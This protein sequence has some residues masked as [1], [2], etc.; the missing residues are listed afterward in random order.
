[1]SDEPKLIYLDSNDFSDLS[2]PIENLNE[3]DR[4]I[5]QAIRNAKKNNTARFFVSPIHLSEA[6]HASETYREQAIS[7]AKLMQELAAGN[8]LQLPT[9][10]CKLELQRAFQGALQVKCSFSEIIS[11]SDQWFGITSSDDNLPEL[12]K[13]IEKNIDEALLPLNRQERRRRKSELDIRKKSGRTAIRSLIK[14]GLRNAPPQK[15]PMSL[16]NPELATKWFLR[17]ATDNDMRE[18]SLRLANDPYVLFKY[19]IDET[20]HRDQLYKI[21]RDQGQKW[22]SFIDTGM[23]QLAPLL[24]NTTKADATLNIKSLRSQVTSEMFWQKVVGA[25]ADTNL[26]ATSQAEI[27]EATKRSP[28]ASVYIHVILETLMNRVHSTR[29][30]AAEGTPTSV[31]AKISD[32]AD[33]Q[34]AMY[35]PYFDVFRCD[36]RIGEVLRHH[37]DLKGR[38]APK[39]SDLLLALQ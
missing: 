35:A 21:V 17:E 37:P 8:I 10:I 6:V 24:A 2:K 7:R 3:Q 15:I 25:L 33:F 16:L 26:G 31:K 38:I 1:M 11:K 36:K 4:T 34:H 32:F 22:A 5:L 27:T 13:E 18:N 30:R 23:S 19:F 9:N 28:S 14:E 20:G 29:T 12:R 39:R